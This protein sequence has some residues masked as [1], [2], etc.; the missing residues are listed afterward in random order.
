MADA[1]YLTLEENA[2]LEL[3]GSVSRL[4]L[5]R[6]ALSDFYSH[7]AIVTDEELPPAARGRDSASLERELHTLLLEED[8][9]KRNYD[10]C[11]AECLRYQQIPAPR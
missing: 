7:T 5:A 11:F 1:T 4:L 9:A 6:Q 8:E 3:E 10:R 2:R